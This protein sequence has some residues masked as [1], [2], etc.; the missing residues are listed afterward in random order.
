MSTEDPVT[1]IL[2]CPCCASTVDAEVAPH[3]QSFECV[4]CGQQWQMVVDEQRHAEYAL[5]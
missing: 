4:T 1:V 2:I 3:H 5:T